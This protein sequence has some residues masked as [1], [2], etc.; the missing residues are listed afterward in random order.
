VVCIFP[1]DGYRYTE[2]I[3]NDQYLWNQGLW[4][5]KLPASPNYVEHPLDADGEW[6]CMR[7]GRRAYAEVVR[8]AAQV[9]AVR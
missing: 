4:L 9:A 6:S 7:W 5:E 1:D 2:T 8:P 3:Y